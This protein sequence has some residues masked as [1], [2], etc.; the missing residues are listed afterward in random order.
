MSSNDLFEKDILDISFVDLLAL[1]ASKKS[2]YRLEEILSDPCKSRFL[3]R[4][5]AVKIDENDECRFSTEFGVRVAL[6]GISWIAVVVPERR[7]ELK[8]IASIL[9]E[10]YR[11]YG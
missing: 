6:A 5:K 1:L 10:I 9:L 11:T 8:K 2:K 4:I 3:K 7:E